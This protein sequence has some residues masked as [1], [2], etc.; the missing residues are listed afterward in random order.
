VA[1]T[2]Q[3]GDHATTFG[4]GP[5]VATVA[6]EV[7]QRIGAPA[8]LAAVRARGAQLGERLAA[9]RQLPTVTEVRGLGMMWGIELTVPAGP[10]VAAA[11]T[12]G[13]LITSAGERVV[14]LLPPL[15]ITAEEIEEGCA[16]LRSVLALS[17]WPR[18]PGPNTRGW[19][20]AAGRT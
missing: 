6:L 11:L 7:V 15:T 3:P 16:V 17:M 1:E 9:L 20:S 8:F 4:G 12:A 13:L 5:L 19:R 2:V 14:R 10:V 18:L